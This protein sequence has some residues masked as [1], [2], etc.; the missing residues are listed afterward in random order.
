MATLSR[1]TSR[2]ARPRSWSSRLPDRREWLSLASGVLVVLLFPG[3]FLYHSGLALGVIPPV[4]GGYIGQVAVAFGV[5][6]LLLNFI[7]VVTRREP[8]L[9]IDKAVFLYSL[10]LICWTQAH[11]SFGDGVQTSYAYY[12]YNIAAIFLWQAIYLGMRNL[13]L[14]HRWLRIV[15]AVSLPV[16]LAIAVYGSDGMFFDTETLAGDGVPV[17]DYQGFARSATLVAFLLLTLTRGMRTAAVVAVTVPL[18]FLLG[19]RSEFVGFILIA[20]LFIVMREGISP[21]TLLWLPAGVLTI[22]YLAVSFNVLGGDSRILELLRVSQDSS[23]QARGELLW[24]ALD[25]ITTHPVLGDYASQLYQG[26]IGDYAHNA[27]S[28]WVSYGLLGFAGFV[29]LLGYA[30]IRSFLMALHGGARNPCIA[31]A[32]I[33]SL[34]AVFLAITAKTVNDPVFAVAW[35]AVACA[36]SQRERAAANAASLRRQAGP[37]LQRHGRH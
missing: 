6:V 25:T 23:Y 3:Y 16:F 18:L 26:D 27:L 10:F 19:A 15:L 31:T 34:Y 11:F 13:N 29:F 12:Y 32:M 30:A 4:L 37:A 35:G 14:D 21:L 28:A 36:L 2:R 24:R 22:G 7:N 17:S 9:F 33:F 8:L 1:L 20:M 5:P